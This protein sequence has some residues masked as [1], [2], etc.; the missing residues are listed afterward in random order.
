MPSTERFGAPEDIAATGRFGS[1]SDIPA[2]AT[3]PT[4]PG[5]AFFGA[6][7]RLP[8]SVQKRLPSFLTNPSTFGEQLATEG[9][10]LADEEKR[11]GRPPTLQERLKLSPATSSPVAM[12]FGTHEVGELPGAMAAAN[13]AAFEK[14]ISADFKRAVK[15]SVSGKATS[16]Q[17][18]KYAGQAR[19]AIDS[20]VEN[21]PNLEFTY[22]TGQTKR[23]EL[24]QSLEEFGDAI[25]QTKQSIFNQYD[26]LAQNAEGAGAK[27]SLTPL[28]TELRTV[29]ADQV[30]ELLH[31]ELAK[32]AAGRADAF[33]EA[34]TLSPGNAQR[35]IT[36]LNSSLKAFYKNPTY[37]TAARANVDAM[38]ANK[39]RS[40]LDEA[41]DSSG[42]EGYQ[43]LK[44]KYGSLKA[45]EKDVNNRAQV[46]GRQ[47]K[48]GGILG[49]IAD[50]GSAEEVIRGLLTFNPVAI[51]RGGALKGWAEFMKYRRNPNRV[52]T[53]MF[54]K[55]ESPEG[56][57]RP[58]IVPSMPMS[59]F[60]QPGLM[61]AQQPTGLEYG[62]RGR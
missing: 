23:G 60:M 38:I 6:A 45:I 33:D 27:V 40:G 25:E 15:P 26:A 41:V 47:E 35:A 32:Y 54:E 56:T 17:V 22:D 61:A 1:H 51:A 50:V 37:E 59:P 28:S 58:P 21:K 20:I 52:V 16:G 24:P 2:P 43:E 36:M 53:S 30:T 39:L 48:G 57:A 7:N 14:A 46:V 12:A 19:S 34:G 62:E 5:T 3:T 8:E 31:P 11:L 4:E 55:A 18:Q 44:N 9:T 49:R 10:R 13:K 42:G 29:A